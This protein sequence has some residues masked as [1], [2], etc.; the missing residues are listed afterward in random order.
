MLIIGCDYHPGFQQIAYVDTDT[1]ETERSPPGT[2]GTGRAVLSRVQQARRDRA[3][4]H[5]SQRHARWFERLLTELQF[6][7]WIG[8]AAAVRTKRVRKQK[9][10]R[11]DAQSENPGTD[12]K[13]GT[14]RGATARDATTEHAS[15]SAPADRTGIRVK[16]G[17]VM[18]TMKWAMLVGSSFCGVRYRSQFRLHLWPA[19]SAACCWRSW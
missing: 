1:G 14:D 16:D 9:T 19:C 12:R 6:E 13:A 8:D 7:L 2:Q 11:Q 5:G 4:G 10:D 3:G 15:R 17:D 18:S